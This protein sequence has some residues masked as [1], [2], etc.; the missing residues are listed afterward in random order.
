[1][2][3]ANW[4]AFS[5]GEHAR[6]VLRTHH[7]FSSGAACHQWKFYSESLALPLEARAERADLKGYSSKL[8]FLEPTFL[9]WL[10]DCSTFISLA[11]SMRKFSL[12]SRQCPLH[13]SC[14]PALMAHQHCA[15]RT[16][17]LFPY[18]HSLAHWF[19]VTSLT[20][21]RS[22]AISVDLP[23]AGTPRR[24]LRWPKTSTQSSSLD[25]VS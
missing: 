11:V 12:S 6:S 22:I 14:M 8:H 10:K 2:L 20:S 23:P 7:S 15:R 16:P 4:K 24:C 25:E 19:C 3:V 18:W 9:L 21:V 1:M 5:S 13:L 17:S